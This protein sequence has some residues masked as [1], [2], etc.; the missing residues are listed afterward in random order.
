MADTIIAPV[1]VQ[2]NQHVGNTDVSRETPVI[3][4][5]DLLTKVS[6][7]R[8]SSPPPEAKNPDSP[9]FFDFKQ[10]ESITDPV[11]K[12]IAVKAYKSMQAG[13]TQKTQAMAERIRLAEQK[14]Q[15][16]QTWSPDRIQ[17]ELLNN[18]Q[19]LQAAQQVAAT[20]PQNPQNSGL[21]NEEFSALTDREK[22][23]MLEL[24]QQVNLLQQTNYQAR[25]Q[26]EDAQLQQK[27]ADYNPQE[28][29]ELWND[30]STGRVQATREHLYII[31]NHK[32][33]VQSA[34][35]YGLE[36]AKQLN[37]TRANGTSVNGMQI[38]NSNGIPTRDKNDTDISFMV[39]LAKFRNAQRKQ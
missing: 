37:Q 36:Q 32:S 1:D 12:D 20:T 19:F 6:Q 24:K 15:E 18:P 34:Y 13:L 28:I 2:P 11:A 39:K 5:P 29:N 16:N 27:Y 25:T 23:Q 17:R 21:T 14:T 8:K 33:I 7:F 26:Q 4:E 30:L 35:E 9:D 22:A 38:D 3:S 10:I 31:K